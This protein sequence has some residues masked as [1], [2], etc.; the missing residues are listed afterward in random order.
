MS[1]R[2]RV[3]VVGGGVSGLD[4]GVPAGRAAGVDVTVR[5]GRRPAGRQARDRSGRRPAA[6]GGRRLVR[7]AQAVG[8]RPVPRARAGGELVTPGAKGA[9]LWTDRGLVAF[10][11]DAP[12]GIPGDIGD[13]VPLAR[14]VAGGPAP[15]RSG[16]GAGQAE[17]RQSRR[18]SAHSCAGAWATRR[19]TWRWRRCWPG[20]T[21]ATSTGC[22]RAPRSRSCVAWEATQGSLIRGSQAAMRSARRGTPTPMFVKP[23]GGVG[24]PARD[25]LAASLGRPGRDRRARSAR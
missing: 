20:C 22:R 7:R 4:D 11:K 23:E 24:A 8:R 5:R 10:L 16:P 1:R 14:R 3:V 2:G 18:R 15:C 13:V 9:Y 19:P 17:G 6:R 25:A 21:R 12:F